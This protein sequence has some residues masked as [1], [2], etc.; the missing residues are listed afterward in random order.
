MASLVLVTFMGLASGNA[1]QG[2]RGGAKLVSLGTSVEAQQAVRIALGGVNAT[3][4]SF[5]LLVNARE[6]SCVFLRGQ[7]MFRD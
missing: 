3:R 7:T 1:A 6:R 4:N 5:L 2:N